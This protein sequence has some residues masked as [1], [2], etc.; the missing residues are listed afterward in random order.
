M[1]R[2]KNPA[3]A[4]AA[5]TDLPWLHRHIPLTRRMAADLAADGLRGRS[6]CLNV[7]LDIK[8][9]PVVDALIAAGARVLVLGCN[10]HTT[11]D[12]VAALMAAHGA[13]VYAWA[14][15]EEPQRREAID[16]VLAHG[17][18]FVSEMGADVLEVV[19]RGASASPPA[20]RAG[21]EATGTGIAKLQRLVPPVPVFNWDDLVLKQGL[22]NRY[23]VGLMVWNTFINV[24]SLTL[25]DR[26]VLVIGYG[27]V[28]QGI[29]E[30]ARAL[31]A[32]VMVC[33]LDPVRQLQARHQGCDVVSL[34]TGLGRAGVVVT[35]TG[36]ERVIG[37]KE[38]PRLQDGCILANAG[39]LNMEIDVPALRRSAHRTVRSMVEEVALG[40]RTVY[41]LAG[42][43]MLNLAAGPGDPYDAFDVTSALM[44][45]GIEFMVRAHAG[46][47]AGVHLLPADVERRV[48]ALAAG[49]P[50]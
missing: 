3:L 14:G 10:P 4:A 17:C 19:S 45:A 35:A 12:A 23:V 39:H 28:G 36:Q 38:F 15:M 13:E 44:L 47:P 25:Y 16:W 41:L 48:A 5:E 40:G 20:L 18:E 49:A 2:I 6:I 9:V 21:L 26:P 29:A 8:M 24:T 34:D 32:R 22:H 33:D 50:R 31:G 37:E 42:G 7:H 1:T 46:F 43:A 27:L 30:Y 11:R